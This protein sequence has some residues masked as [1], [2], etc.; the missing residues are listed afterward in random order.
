MERFCG[1]LK[2]QARSKSQMNVSLANSVIISEHLNHVGFVIPEAAD[3]TD[4][5]Q[6]YPQLLGPVKMGLTR[7]QKS[8]LESV[9]GRINLE[10][11]CFNRCQLGKTLS[12][13][14]TYSQR[15]GDINRNDYR[16]YYLLPGRHEPMFGEV[17]F[18][19]NVTE[20]GRWAWMRKLND[21]NVDAGRGVVSYSRTGS[22][23]SV[24]VEYI[25]SLVGIIRTAD[26]NLVVTDSDLFSN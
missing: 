5:I 22:L 25:K 8:A 12:L 4:S 1:I 15:R 23:H 24:R 17:Q 18:Y 26:V 2:P 20:H 19:A 21:I 13:G 6:Q 11:V 10:V 7:Y 14:S 16:V 3:A 9:L